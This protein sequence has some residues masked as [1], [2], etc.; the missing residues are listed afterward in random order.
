MVQIS[1]EQNQLSVDCESIV[2]H[3]LSKTDILQ[4]YL[5]I[6]E[7]KFDF[8]DF[9]DFTG[10]LI[11]NEANVIV[12]YDAMGAYDEPFTVSVMGY[13]GIYFVQANEFDDIG[14]FLNRTS[15]EVAAKEL[16]ENYQ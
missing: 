6:S 4:K 11:K 9:I 15:S 5:E 1:Q 3:L 7:R 2:H 13:Q 10:D 14:F 12:S 16:A 8:S